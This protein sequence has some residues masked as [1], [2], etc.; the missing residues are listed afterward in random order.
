MTLNGLERPFTLCMN[1]FFVA[2]SV[3]VNVDQYQRRK[4][5]HG[6][7]DFSNV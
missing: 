6:C 2:R 5:P 1:S 3:E 7:V 4:I